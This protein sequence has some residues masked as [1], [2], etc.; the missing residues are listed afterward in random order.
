M[1]AAF[2]TKVRSQ[3]STLVVGGQEVE[4]GSRR[5]I[6]VR[7]PLLYTHTPVVLSVRVIRG[8]RPGPTLFVSG[9]VHGDEING[10]EIVRR[11]LRSPEVKHLRGALI[12]VP[13][14]NVYGFV[15]QSRYLPDRRDLNR[16]FPGSEQGSLAAR[17]AHA[18][19][20]EVVSK[21]NYGIDLHT[22]A[23]HRDNLPQIRA[24]FK[25]GETVERLAKAFGTPVILNSD[26]RDG[27]LREAACELGVPVIVYEGGEALRFD[28]TVIRA[29][30]RGVIGVM[31]SLE[32][33]RAPRNPLSQR[34]PEPVVARSSYWVRAPQSGILRAVLPLGARVE[35]RT[36]LGI[37]ADPMGEHEVPVLA[38]SA[39]MVIG[40]VNLPLVNEG[41][42][43]YH[44]ARFGE[45]DSAA[46]A[47]ERF[48]TETGPESD[49]EPPPEIPISE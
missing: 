42:A 13:V 40:K 20:Q 26:I 4:P 3:M 31:R 46:E 10:V 19:L 48:Q 8:R 29:G 18:F 6:E 43:I 24:A 15:R 36:L 49:L 27:S 14:V 34:R 32:M 17:L 41:E 11:V 21:C 9:A 45:P 23:V 5:T 30:V 2:A 39:G 7:L 37:I 44:I 25:S 47:V 16:T 28:E 12:A 35:K 22:G 33:L 1:I 38:P